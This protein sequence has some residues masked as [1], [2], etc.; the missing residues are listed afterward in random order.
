M[1]KVWGRNLLLM[2]AIGAGIAVAAQNPD[3]GAPRGGAVQRKKGPPAPVAGGRA[4]QKPAAD[5]EGA[6]A[7][8]GQ[9]RGNGLPW[10][11]GMASR[12]WRSALPGLR[13]AIAANPDD[14]NLQAYLGVINARIGRYAEAA[15]AFQLALGSEVYEEQGVER[16]A[17]ALR[18]TGHPEE[19]FELRRSVWLMTMNVN[20]AAPMVVGMVDDL[21]YAGDNEGAEDWAWYLISEVP[22]MEEAYAVAADVALDRGDLDEAG[23]LLWMAD[24]YGHRVARTRAARGRLE[25]AYGDLKAAYGEVRYGRMRNRNHLPWAIQ[26]ESLRLQGGAHE[27]LALLDTG[28]LPDKER[29]D[30]TAARLAALASAGQL[31][32]A[33]ELRRIALWS[34]PSNP[35]VLAASKVLDLAEARAASGSK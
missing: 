14:P 31:E 18:Y 21:R 3:A 26:A 5:A 32:E 19:A 11:V 24:L 7:E 25:M 12:Q 8:S 17:D 33:R 6:G 28:H 4:R 1:F 16:H 15:V 2:L 30:M 9:R 23:Y 27:A 20:Q 29:P 13:A 22:Q 34:Y 10:K 35:D